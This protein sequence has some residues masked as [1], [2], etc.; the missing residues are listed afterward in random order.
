MGAESVL[1]ENWDPPP[2]PKPTPGKPI[3]NADSP[4]SVKVG[5]GRM[6]GADAVRQ[7]SYEPWR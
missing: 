4:H 5:A 7:A 6:P 1:E 2:P 3:H